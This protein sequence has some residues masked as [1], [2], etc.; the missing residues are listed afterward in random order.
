M[1]E[2]G[3]YD[4]SA[5]GSEYYG[6]AALKV[7]GAENARPHERGSASS[8]SKKCSGRARPRRVCVA[9]DYVIDLPPHAP[10]II[11]ADYIIGVVNSVFSG[12][13]S[14][15]QNDLIKSIAQVI[16]DEIK[17]EIN[18]AKFVSVIA[19]ET[20]DI[21]HREQMS[22]IFRYLTKTGIEERFVDM[23]RVSSV[24][25]RRG[26]GVEA[27][28]RINAMEIRSLRSVCG[29]SKKD[30]PRFEMGAIRQRRADLPASNVITRH[31]SAQKNQTEG[32]FEANGKLL[33]QC[34]K[35]FETSWCRLSTLAVPLP[36]DIRYE[37]H[38]CSKDSKKY[39]VK[40]VFETCH[41]KADDYIYTV[42][43]YVRGQSFSQS[44]MSS[45][46]MKA[47]SETACMRAPHTNDL[48]P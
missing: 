36:I 17:S 34:A 22:V 2:H 6:V 37:D 30:K 8:F 13:S 19:D 9:V 18:F 29:V 47:W 1:A 43:I 41:L 7:V 14:D 28:G 16:R 32:V 12:L 5:E 31:K 23:I 20:P 3:G 35:R 39:K 24:L 15:I 48:R 38:I 10:L 40:K 21:S 33:K 27:I 25:L 42:S 4:K 11:F 44:R 46:E 45:E 26:G